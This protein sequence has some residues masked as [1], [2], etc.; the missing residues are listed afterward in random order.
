MSDTPA[1]TKRIRNPRLSNGCLLCSYHHHLTH[2]GEWDITMATD[3]IPELIPPVRIDPHRT[4]RR[5]ERFT[6]RTRC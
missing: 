3:G 1:L 6:H 4:P 5:H 2:Q